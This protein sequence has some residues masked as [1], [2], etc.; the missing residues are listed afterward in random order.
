AALQLGALAKQSR[1]FDEALELFDRAL[2]LRPGDAGVR[3][4]IATLDFATGRLD[5]ARESLESLVRESPGFREAHV[6]LATIY[7]RLKRKED[8]D[9]ERAIVRRLS[10]DSAKEPP[11]K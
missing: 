5:E 11:P 4:Q 2:N 1:Q 6:T 8:G 9:R 7:Y 3:Y 10:D